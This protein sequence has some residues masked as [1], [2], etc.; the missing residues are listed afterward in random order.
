M[1]VLAPSGP[2]LTVKTQALPPLPTATLQQQLCSQSGSD[3]DVLFWIRLG[4]LDTSL[5]S[6]AHPASPVGEHQPRSSHANICT[7]STCASASS[8]PRAKAARPCWLPGSLA[9]SVGCQQ[10]NAAVDRF[11]SSAQRAG[12]PVEGDQGA[13]KGAVMSP[14]SA[15]ACQAKRSPSS[16]HSRPWI[17]ATGERLL[18]SKLVLSRDCCPHSSD[19]WAGHAD[20]S[21]AV[22]SQRSG[23]GKLGVLW[24][25]FVA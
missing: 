10:G 18:F 9:G 21:V 7:S 20:I 2:Q 23:E 13:P 12:T 22:Q 25:P 19:C 4:Q 8:L 5:L 17:S 16:Q 15:A 1:G 3:S 24:P 14:S 11:A 6:A